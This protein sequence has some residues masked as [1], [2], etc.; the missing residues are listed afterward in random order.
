MTTGADHCRSALPPP[1]EQVLEVADEEGT[2]ALARALGARCGPGT[3]FALH[4]DLGAGKTRFAQGLALALGVDEP[5]CSPTFTIINE[6]V[7]HHG[8][9]FVHMDLYRLTDEAEVEDLGFEELLERATQVVIEWPERA[10]ALLPVDTVHVWIEPG[11]T[12]THRR[13]RIAIPAT[14]G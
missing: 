8:A 2:V 4:G 11:S 14:G 13:I 1:S 5:V 10:G 3:V 6:H 12:E 9:R 7:G